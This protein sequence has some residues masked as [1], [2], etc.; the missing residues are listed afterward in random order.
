MTNL[1]VKITQ[2]SKNLIYS[3]IFYFSF[4]ST[5]LIS[6]LTYDIVLSPDFEKYYQYFEFYSGQLDSPSLEQGNLY[7]Y[8]N[9]LF[10]RILTFLNT[11]YSIN[12]VVN[13]SIY[14]VNAMIFLFACIGLKKYLDLFYKSHNNFL[15]LSILCFIPSSFELRSTL[16]PEILGFAI[17]SW[18]IYYLSISIRQL[19]NYEIYKVIILFA[20]LINTKISLAIIG[21]L[22]IFLHMYF[23]K[24]TFIK[25]IKLKHIIIFVVLTI[26]LAVE[27][28][29][30]N[31]LTINE[32][33]HTQNYNNKA[34]LDF[35][36]NINVKLLKNNPDRYFHSDSFISITLFDTFNDFF[37][38]YWNSEYTQLNTERAEFFKISTRINQ[39]PP[40]KIKFDKENKVFTLSGNFDNRWNDE[41]Y[42]NETRMRFTY[43]FSV[44]FYIL[45]FLF[46][47]F[48][49]KF[50]AIFL[51]PFLAMFIISLSA[52]GVLGTNNFDPLISDSV[53][54]FYYSYIILLSFSV[55]LSE[56]FNFEILKKLFSFFIILLFLFFLGFPFNYS[57]TSKDII[58]YNN[59][60]IL[61]CELNQ[62]ITNIYFQIDEIY[63]GDTDYFSN[64]IFPI[65][66][67]R[68]LSNNISKVPF[69]NMFLFF[70]YFIFDS[71]LIKTN[72]INYGKKND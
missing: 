11:A 55:L 59:S 54:T 37:Q 36:T 44:I 66:Q 45:L 21:I 52:L 12:Q 19:T 14:F 4:Y 1:I 61:T 27:N 70:S 60:L 5:S 3:I 31:G 17:L 28:F 26:F 47:F 7:F 58:I 63:C 38:L 33:N 18:L 2:N 13:I 9:F 56:I 6:Y 25:Y 8:L 15:V 53:K 23:Q 24:N 41:N 57:D 71:K 48:K 39:E 50:R 32:V 43:I 68:P 62:Q 34:S 65:K 30:L 49:R 67:A 35:F 29:A 42:I 16:K 64:K 51:A 22:F 40:I 10:I 46:S 69:I 72:S 20:L